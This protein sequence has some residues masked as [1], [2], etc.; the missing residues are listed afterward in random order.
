MNTWAGGG[1]SQ[2]LRVLA[3][4][5]ALGIV[6][7]F[8]H[9]AAPLI[10][11]LFFAFIIAIIAAPLMVWLHERGLPRWLAFLIT[12]AIIAAAVF[13]LTL[14]L[15]MAAAQLTLAVPTY[16]VEMERFQE[17]TSAALAAMSGD[18]LDLSALFGM[19]ELGQLLEA[20]AAFLANLL[21]FLSDAFL[22]VLFVVFMLAQAFY[23]PELLRREADAGNR[24]ARRLYQYGQTLQRY[25]TITALIGLVTGG[26][27]T[28]LFLLLG[29]PNPLLWGAVA[30][31][32][33]FVPTIGFWLAAIPPT[34][35]GLLE[36]GPLI[37]LLTLAG[38]L[39][40]NGFADNVVKP[41]YIGEGLNLAPFMVLFSIVLW[42]FVLGPAGAILG[43]PMT[44]LFKDVLLEADEGTAWM[45]RLMGAAGQ[46]EAA[47]EIL[48]TA[49]AAAQDDM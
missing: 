47:P 20:L 48:E 22:L 43:V 12:L 15:A 46:L 41:R 39:L 32:L 4:L 45:A 24:Y 5:A 35:L 40:I 38:I 9:L 31:L 23:T 18:L 6:L 36:H 10:S 2:T 30:F 25:I 33:S 19:V 27:D 14:F 42:S 49:V 37:A 34:L 11:T 7:Y 26:L 29:I 28:I 1:S 3:G 44:M 21:G 8:M 13:A 16:I 17:T